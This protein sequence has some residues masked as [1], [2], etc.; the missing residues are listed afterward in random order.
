MKIGSS[1]DIKVFETRQTLNGIT[2]KTVNSNSVTSEE[3]IKVWSQS[4]QILFFFFFLFGLLSLT[5]CNIN[6]NA[7]KMKCPNIAKIP[8]KFLCITKKGLGRLAPEHH[9][10]IENDASNLTSKF[11]KLVGKTARYR[12]KYYR[13]IW[14]QF[15]QHFT[16][17]F[18]RQYF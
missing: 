3:N 13:L 18:L 1:F 5:V 15:H 12:I 16:R 7:F 14:C 2:S 9:N 17:T 6:K 8:V 11:L 4:Y 10:W